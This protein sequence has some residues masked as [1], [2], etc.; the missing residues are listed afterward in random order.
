MSG[1]A[2]PLPDSSS[3]VGRVAGPTLHAVDEETVHLVVLGMQQ[4]CSAVSTYIVNGVRAGDENGRRFHCI[5]DAPGL[6]YSQCS[7][8]ILHGRLSLSAGAHIYAYEKGP[9]PTKAERGDL[10]VEV[11]YA[12]PTR[13]ASILDGLGHPISQQGCCTSVRPP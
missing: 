4:D 9:A 6:H 7:A 5:F 2:G 12:T 8:W 13:L 10:Q 3:V 11:F 1:P